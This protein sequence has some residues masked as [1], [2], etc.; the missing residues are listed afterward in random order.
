[1]GKSAG[2]SMVRGWQTGGMSREKAEN[3]VE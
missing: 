3:A 1:V 2:L